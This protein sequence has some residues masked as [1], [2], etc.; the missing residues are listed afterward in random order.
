MTRKYLL[1][2]S[3][4]FFGGSL[5]SFS[6]SARA[7]ACTPVVYAFRHAEDA[8]VHLTPV[9]QQHAALYPTM[10]DGF[11]S[12]HNYCPVGFVYSMYDTNPNGTYG[13]Y[14]PYE[15]AQ[16]L[17]VRAC[18]NYTLALFNLDELQF[19][20]TF[21]PDTICT[22][23]PGAGS[24]SAPNMA[25][26]NGNKLYEYLGETEKPAMIPATGTQLV[27]ELL[28]NASV[29]GGLSSAIFWTSQG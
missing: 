18:Y 16:P 23:A 7:Q 6:S 9:G 21:N 20:G 28:S 17:A 10:I 24:T 4:L 3:L 27:A 11:G 22:G 19:S 14:N 5:L 1:I 26:G 13:T 8:G 2:Y 29:A 12:A 15:T 25:L